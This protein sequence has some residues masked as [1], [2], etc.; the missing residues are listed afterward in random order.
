M[1]SILCAIYLIKKS[2]NKFNVDKKSQFDRFNH[3]TNL[4]QKNNNNDNNNKN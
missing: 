4:K 2:L 3:R 1:K